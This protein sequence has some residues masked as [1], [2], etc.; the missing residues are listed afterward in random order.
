MEDQS[1]LS[2]EFLDDLFREELE[3]RRL[4]RS[5]PLSS[6]AL[7]GVAGYVLARRSGPVILE[8][9]SR[10]ATEKVTSLVEEVFEDGGA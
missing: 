9:L 4:V 6:L 8:A 3:W 1:S 5:Y 7:A 10:S 2:S